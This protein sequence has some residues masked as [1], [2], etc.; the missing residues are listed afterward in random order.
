FG[1]RT[2]RVAELIRS[3]SSA[4]LARFGAGDP[5]EIEIDGES[6][7]LMPEE[8]DL[9]QTARGEAVVEAEGGFTM[10]LDTII[11]PDLRREGLARE[12]INRIQRLRKDSGLEVSDRIDLAVAGAAEV[13]EAAGAFAE[14][15]MAETL[16]VSIDVVEGDIAPDSSPFRREVD[17]DGV[18]G[19]ISIARVSTGS[20]A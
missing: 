6:V 5:L 3:L 1:K 15:I 20:G 16:A 7:L 18:A 2:P 11:T 13:R 12:L 8:F 17:L 10:A 4:D 14:F 19:T 9:V